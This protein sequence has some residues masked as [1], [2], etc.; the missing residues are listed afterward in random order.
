M[1]G[2]SQPLF[3]WVRELALGSF[4]NE[5]ARPMPGENLLLPVGFA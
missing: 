4:R 1:I 5:R 2:A 3:A